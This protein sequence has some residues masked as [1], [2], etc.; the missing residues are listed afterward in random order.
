MIKCIFTVGM[1]CVFSVGLFSNLQAASTQEPYT[2]PAPDSKMLVCYEDTSHCQILG[3]RDAAI[4]KPAEGHKPF[5]GQLQFDIAYNNLE[6]KSTGEESN[7]VCLYNDWVLESK[8]GYG[9]EPASKEPSGWKCDG[10][11]Y[12]TCRGDI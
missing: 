1:A 6:D 10:A 8:F 7:I 9:H 5:R 2:C 4:W 12:C 11:P 3:G